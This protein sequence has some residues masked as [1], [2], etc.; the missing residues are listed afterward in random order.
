MKQ[1]ILVLGG[2]EFTGRAVLRALRATDWAV[3]V[4]ALD[5]RSNPPDGNVESRR[6]EVTN[7]ESI[8]AALAGINGV[9]NCISSSPGTIRSSTSALFAAAT[10]LP[11]PPRVVHIS[12]MSVYGSI[13]GL[14]DESMPLLGDLGDYGAAKIAAETTAAAYSHVTILRPGCEFGPDSDYW[15]WRTARLLQARRLG[16]LGPAGDGHC[17]LVDIGDVVAAVL[18][19]LT[20]ATMPK[21]AFNLANPQVSSWN[22]VLTRYAIALRAVPVRRI[23]ARR[24]KIESRLLAPPFKVAEIVARKCGLGATGAP[25]P[26]PSSLVRLMSQDIRLDSRRAEVDLGIRWQDLDTTLRQTARWVLDGA[27]AIAD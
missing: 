14:V 16:D 6:V 13:Q 22:E 20:A 11:V 3:P 17:N 2:D 8:R 4:A 25:L 24:L 5:A 10:A 26:L 12:S 27:G 15:G 21:G 9:V 18:Y 7:T 19:S 1:S 23:S